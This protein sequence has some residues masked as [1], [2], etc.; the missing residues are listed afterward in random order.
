V[1]KAISDLYEGL[2]ICGETLMKLPFPDSL[3]EAIGFLAKHKVDGDRLNANMTK[4]HE[5]C[6]GCLASSN[7]RLIALEKGASNLKHAPLA[8]GS[9]GQF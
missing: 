8:Q 4:M 5:H 3:V 2:G 6:K 9:G 1:W 7:A